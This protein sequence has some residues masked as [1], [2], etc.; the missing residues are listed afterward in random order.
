MPWAAWL[1][2]AVVVL[3]P[4]VGAL[5]ASEADH[6]DAHDCSTC[7]LVALS[8]VVDLRPPLLTTR[9]AVEQRSIVAAITRTKCALHARPQL[10]RAPPSHSA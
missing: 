5:H 2:V 1:V 10:P 3:T 4:L 6:A 7:D 9:L 8:W